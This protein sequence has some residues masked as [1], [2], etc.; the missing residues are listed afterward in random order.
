M[1][2]IDRVEKLDAFNWQPGRPGYSLFDTDDGIRR[3]FPCGSCG[4]ASTG[5]AEADPSLGEKGLAGSEN[6][7]DLE[8][9]F[10]RERLAPKDQIA[11]A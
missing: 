1:V 10:T 5:L 9:D 4:S 3:I 7:N 8:L 2:H 6:E 11:T